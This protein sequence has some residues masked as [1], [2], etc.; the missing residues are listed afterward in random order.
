MAGTERR[1]CNGPDL[2]QR[3]QQHAQILHAR[4]ALHLAVHGLLCLAHLALVRLALLL[5]TPQRIQP[6]LLPAAPGT[7]NSAR[8]KAI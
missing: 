6:L 1:G 8:R 4:P 5:L 7:A 2:M 3:Q